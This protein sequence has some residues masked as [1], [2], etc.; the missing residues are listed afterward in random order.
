MQLSL[1]KM[2]NKE[3]E[4]IIVYRLTFLLYAHFVFYLFLFLLHQK[5]D[6]YD[7]F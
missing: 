5:N 2:L 6:L 4:P 3:I 7:V 1:V